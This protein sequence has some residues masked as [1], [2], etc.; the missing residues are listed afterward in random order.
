MTYTS[1]LVK[2]LVSTIFIIASS[3]VFQPKTVKDVP[4]IVAT[5][6]P[7]VVVKKS[8]LKTKNNCIK[9]VSL[10]KKYDWPIED[11]MQ[12]CKDESQ[13]DPENINWGDIHKDSNGN[14]LC[15]SSQGLFQLACFWP[16]K[17]GYEMAD[18]LDPEKNIAMGYLIWL[19]YGFDPWSTY[20]K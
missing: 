1:L 17:L 14:I 12:I 15:I 20:E 7:T 9:Y 13:G 8:I 16:E 11:T 19:K 2:L 4:I 3:M 6:T 10:I 18:L 5:T